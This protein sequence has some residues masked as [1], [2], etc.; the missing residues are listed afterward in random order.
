[1]ER[2]NPFGFRLVPLEVWQGSK[3][4]RSFVTT[5]GQGIFEQIAKYIAEGTGAYAENQHKQEVVLNTFQNETIDNIISKQRQSTTRG[6]KNSINVPDLHE[7]IEYL[8]NLNTPSIIESI[9]IS[10][11]YVKRLNGREEFYSFK[12]VKPNIDQTAIAKKNLLSLRVSDKNFESYFALP[13]N[14]AGDGKSYLE[15]GHPLPKKLFDMDDE[16]FVLVGA[17]LWNKLGEDSNTYE[18][19]LKIFE[20]SGERSTKWIRREYFRYRD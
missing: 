6:K 5:L 19:L 10:D 7:E 18:E 15:A 14:P 8:Q 16:D 4:E 20:E 3:F 2:N 12:T 9:I 11:L 13:Y 1:V 17:P